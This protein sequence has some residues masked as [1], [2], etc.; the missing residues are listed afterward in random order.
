MKPAYV[1]IAMAPLSAALLIAS[2][3]GARFGVWDC[4]FGFQLVRWSPYAGLATAALALVGARRP[5]AADG[6]RRRPRRCARRRRRPSRTCPG[7]GGRKRARL[8]RSTTSR[9]TPRIRLR[10]SPSFRCAPDLPCRRTTPARD[11]A[12]KQHSAYPDI[13]P[14]DLPLPPAAAYARALDVAK[15]FGWDIA[16]AD[17]ASRPHRGD[18]DDA[19]VRLSRRR[20]HPRDADRGRQPRR[21][22]L[23]VARRPGRPRDEREARARVPREARILTVSATLPTSSRRHA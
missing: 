16:A 2:G 10:S 8:R 21:R 3:Y 13:R 15:A 4:R 6:P 23:A 14:V 12:A 19:L 1:P 17:A 18:G 9:P 11:V 5:A 7:N 20:R 22:P